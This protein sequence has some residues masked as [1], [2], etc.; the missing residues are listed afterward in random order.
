MSVAIRRPHRA[1]RT[2]GRPCRCWSATG[3]RSSIGGGRRARSTATATPSATSTTTTIVRFRRTAARVGP[4]G[5]RA[6]G[7]VAP[8]LEGRVR[9]VLGALRRAHLAEPPRAPSQGTRRPLTGQSVQHLGRPRGRVRIRCRVELGRHGTSPWTARGQSRRTN[10]G[11]RP[12]RRYRR[13]STMT[14]R[15]T[16]LRSPV[17]AAHPR[18]TAG[19][20]R[21]GGC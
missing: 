12:G 7:A 5:R 2:M 20:L 16:G 21:T 4:T 18:A 6:A 14:S 3:S 1:P 17:R 19:A 15:R 10:R 13:R 9:P 8:A 11:K